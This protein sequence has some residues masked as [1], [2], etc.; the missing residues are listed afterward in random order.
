[1]TTIMGMAKQQQAR[2]GGV[3]WLPAATWCAGRRIV[4]VPAGSMCWLSAD[5][6]PDSHPQLPAW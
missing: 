5:M 6:N 2:S 1:M 3:G 4:V